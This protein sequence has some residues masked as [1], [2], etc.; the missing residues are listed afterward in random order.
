MLIVASVIVI[1]L[2]YGVR[3]AMPPAP[4]TSTPHVPLSFEEALAA[5]RNP[6]PS[7][8]WSDLEEYRGINDYRQPPYEANKLHASR[9]GL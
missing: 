8:R 9:R 2:A 7:E 1:S 3:L 6:K 5:A 4:P